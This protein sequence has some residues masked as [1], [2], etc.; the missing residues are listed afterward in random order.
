MQS[1]EPGKPV[2]F[3]SNRRSSSPH[4]QGASSDP[5]SPNLAPEHQHYGRDA[6]LPVLRQPR[7]SLLVNNP[8][9]V[10]I[11]ADHDVMRVHCSG[12]HA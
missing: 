12:S 9:D 4:T 10:P 3:K 2:L 11:W 5:Q 8:T 1:I 6:G 7:S